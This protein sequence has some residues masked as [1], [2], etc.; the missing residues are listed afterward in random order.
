VGELVDDYE[1][2]RDWLAAKEDLLVDAWTD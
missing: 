2:R 1:R